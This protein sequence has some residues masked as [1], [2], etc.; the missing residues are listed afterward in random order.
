M[1]ATA[2][3]PAPAVVSRP[4]ADPTADPVA[5]VRALPDEQQEAI[6]V[7]IL[8]AIIEDSGGKGYIP[9]EYAGEWLGYFVPPAA[10]AE[11][12]KMYGPKITPERE[13]EI[14]LAFENP[15]RS[16]TTEEMLEWLDSEEAARIQ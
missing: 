6:F 2:T 7:S 5:F 3:L 4:A 9:V 15:G 12:F 8:K 11:L 10:A 16:F 1:S 13:A 14:Q